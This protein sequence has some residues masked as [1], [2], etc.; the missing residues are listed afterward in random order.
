MKY[1]LLVLL[2]LPLMVVA[3]APADTTRPDVN[4]YQKVD[5][6]PRPLNFETFTKC[7]RY[8][9]LAQ[10]AGIGGKVM[11][12]VL[13]DEKG[14]PIS[15]IILKSPHKSLAEA[16]EPCLYEMLFSPA[17]IEGKPLKFWVVVPIEFTP[18]TK[19]RKKN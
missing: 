15:H 11:V 7:L 4:T 17:L 2:S 6:Q 10:N 1:I 19:G 16:V 12:K 13:I 18:R 3:Q 9:E 8:P 5:T 14:R